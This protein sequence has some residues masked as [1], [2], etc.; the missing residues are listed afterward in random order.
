MGRRPDQNHMYREYSGILNS[1][2]PQI[3]CWKGYLSVSGSI[4]ISRLHK[5]YISKQRG[6]LNLKM[7]MFAAES[8]QVCSHFCHGF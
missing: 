1:D 8:L 3:R 7:D 2:I 5:E 6:A 4:T